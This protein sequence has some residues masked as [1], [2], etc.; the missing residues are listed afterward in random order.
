MISYLKQ[1]L[2][3]LIL[4]G[5]LSACSPGEQQNNGVVMPV[6]GKAMPTFQMNTLDGKQVRSH[7]QFAGKVII[8]NVWATWCPPCRKE[9]PDL[10]RLSRLLPSNKFTVIGLAADDNADDV[11][12]FVEKHKIPFPIFWDKSGKQLTGPVLGVFKY[13]ETFII[14]RRGILVEKVIGGFPWAS[15][16]MVSVLNT[17]YKTGQLPE[18]AKKGS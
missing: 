5:L 17:V 16:N 18:P 6:K 14:N 7:D 10:I 9:M 3:L 11:S 15:P 13:P 1:M 8:L 12:A 4:G 2:Y